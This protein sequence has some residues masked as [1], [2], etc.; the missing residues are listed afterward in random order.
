MARNANG[1]PAAK[2]GSAHGIESMMQVTSFKTWLTLWIVGGVLVGLVLWS[3]FG[4]LPERIDGEGML[5]AAGGVQQIRAAAAGQ[6][7][8]IDIKVNDL[9]KEDQI[10]G[11]LAAASMDENVKAAQAKYDEAIRQY[12]LDRARDSTA[13][14]QLQAE[15]ARKAG[16]VQST[17]K[18]LAAAEENL[19]KKLIRVDDRDAVKRR[20]DFALADV[21]AV[22]DQ[23]RSRQTNIARSA[24]RVESARVEL[25]R[26]F[27]TT[28]RMSEMKSS[29]TGRIVNVLRKAGDIVRPGE[30]IA[31]IESAAGGAELVAV[32]FIGARAGKKIAKGQPVVVSV[33]QFRPEE[34][35]KLIGVV[36]SVSEFPESPATIAKE[37]KES[38]IE[39]ASYRVT[40]ALQ[41]DPS[42]FTK[43]AWTNG[44]GPGEAIRSGTRIKVEV[45][46]RA[47]A[48]ITLIFPEKRQK[49]APVTT[50]A[51]NRQPGS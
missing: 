48:P 49:A 3:I 22:D 46:T 39:E 18:E 9:V 29:V 25:E 44:V 10:V 43:F 42:T 19:Q 38:E 41:T 51:G 8:R 36:D 21:A 40:V 12:D 24:S 37:M 50:Q 17:R 35:G 14:A 16:I 6:I 26:V 2:S 27:S 11:T 23:I 31:E 32:G 30:A 28:T 20:Y 33:Y 4:S 45:Q 34:F 15:R 7:R 1:L 13:I 47:R 5:R